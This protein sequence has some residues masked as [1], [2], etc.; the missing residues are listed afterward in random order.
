[1]AAVTVRSDFG[2][3]CHCFHFFPFYLRW[4]DGTRCHD[5]SFFW[6]FSFK[7]PFTF[8]SL[9]FKRLFSSSLLS[10]IRVV[11]SAY[12][13]LL[14]FPRGNLYG[15]NLKLSSRYRDIT[16]QQHR[17]GDMEISIS[18][19]SYQISQ[20]QSF[21]YHS[22]LTLVMG[23]LS[24]PTPRNSDIPPTRMR[25]PL[26]ATLWEWN[27]LWYLNTGGEHPPGETGTAVLHRDL[28]AGLSPRHLQSFTLHSPWPP[29]HH[30]LL[31]SHLPSYKFVFMFL[32]RVR[33]GPSQKPYPFHILI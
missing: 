24:S 21:Q 11:P 31:S 9:T 6:M 8:S 5:L 2:A 12:L 16:Y 1:M 10:A 19:Q 13:R 18:A 14:V 33:W 15:Y 32:T 29:A 28:D 7:P 3:Q 20:F 30:T 25:P 22:Y 4:S 27:G 23:G 17:L 26:P